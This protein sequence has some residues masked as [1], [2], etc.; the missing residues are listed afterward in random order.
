MW[1]LQ[2]FC[3]Q[4]KHS[5]RSKFG[6]FVWVSKIDRPN[7]NEHKHQSIFEITI[8]H[9]IAILCACD[10]T[11]RTQFEF[12]SELVIFFCLWRNVTICFHFTYS[13]IEITFENVYL[14]WIAFFVTFNS[15][16]AWKQGNKEEEEEENPFYEHC[17]IW[18]SYVCFVAVHK[19]SL[20]NH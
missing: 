5:C 7:T 15:L 10:S 12:W 14:G 16:N 6:I 3:H 11:C 13:F 8:G 4:S 9:R 19:C 18:K 20:T 1:S 17:T 2:D